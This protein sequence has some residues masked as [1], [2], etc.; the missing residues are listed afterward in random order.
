M[1]LFKILSL[2]LVTVMFNSCDETKDLADVTINTNFTESI[3]LGAEDGENISNE[4]TETLELS[5]DEINEYVDKIKSIKINKITYKLIEFS[6][7]ENCRFT[8]V[9]MYAD[10]N[11][12]ETNEY[13][14]KTVADNGTVYTVTDEEKLATMATSFMIDN[15]VVFKMTG[16]STS[17]G[18]SVFKMQIT[19]D[20]TI[21]A[22]PL[23]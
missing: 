12:F 17:D 4:I 23:N 21:V 15:K 19:F 6:G 2:V 16:T 11:L 5:N 20:L 9:N 13:T 1:K 18:I 10:N 3:Q 22:S 14:I 7:D 8:D